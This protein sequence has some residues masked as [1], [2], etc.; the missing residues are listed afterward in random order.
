MAGMLAIALTGVGN[1]HPTFAIKKTRSYIEN[2]QRR[3]YTG[4]E[5]VIILALVSH[6]LELKLV[7]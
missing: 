3:L 5:S 7:P 6:P 4:C 1:P 2:Y